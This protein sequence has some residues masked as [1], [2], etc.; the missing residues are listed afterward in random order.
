MNERG[1]QVRASLGTATKRGRQSPDFLSKPEKGGIQ[2]TPPL[3][4]RNQQVV[5]SSPTARLQFS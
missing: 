2:R 4:I 5:G 1:I 3:G